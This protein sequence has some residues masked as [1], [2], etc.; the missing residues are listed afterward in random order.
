MPAR[1]NSG[2][3]CGNPARNAS[4]DGSGPLL[5]VGWRVPSTEDPH[6]EAVV[7]QISQLN[8][9]HEHWAIPALHPLV[10]N[11]VVLMRTVKNLLA[12][13]FLTGKRRWEVPT[14]DPF[15]PLADA[16]PS[17]PFSSRRRYLQTDCGSASGAMPRSAL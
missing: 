12:V 1:S 14:D 8:R 9:D 5:S 17:R 4:T 15:E 3:C 7:E 11:D 6:I 2:R 10:V 16:R 13:D